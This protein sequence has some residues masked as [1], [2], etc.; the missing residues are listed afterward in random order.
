MYSDYFS[1]VRPLNEL[2]ISKIFSGMSQYFQEFRSCNVGS[3]SGIWCGNC[4]KCTSTYLTLFPFLG[5]KTQEIFG[6]DLFADEK[7]IPIVQGLMRMNNIV[8]PFECTAS[9]DEIK[10]AI[11]LSI[12][13][14][15]G[16][17]LPVVLEAV[18]NY[19]KDNPKLLED[20][21]NENYLPENYI[22][23]LKNKL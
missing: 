5:E 10:Y 3:K 13:K 2:E 4:P 8:K 17:S 7:L 20:W 19:A 16:Q 11:F 14:F 18:K 23:L 6:K 12:Q 22:E 21:N 1:F 15:E 9:V